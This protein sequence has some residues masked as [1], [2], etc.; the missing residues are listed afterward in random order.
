[1]KKYTILIVSLFTLMIQGCSYKETPKFEKKPEI[2][3]EKELKIEEPKKIVQVLEIKNMQELNQRVNSYLNERYSEDIKERLI[4][5]THYN[6]EYVNTQSKTY[7]FVKYKNSFLFCGSA[8]CSAAMLEYKEKSL[9]EI[10]SFTLVKSSIYLIHD[11]S[12]IGFSKIVVP[13]SF[14][15][16]AQWSI[17]YNVYEPFSQND[18]SSLYPNDREYKELKAY[19][20]SRKKSIKLFM[21]EE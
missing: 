4:E 17:Y 7:I 3:L 20:S 6:L 21:E 16:E 1:M 5:G 10:E 11:Y 19:L 12:T 2:Q 14:L 8:G 18:N 13:V 15:D 9:K